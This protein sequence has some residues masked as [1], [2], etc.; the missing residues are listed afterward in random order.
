VH[1]VPMQSQ[2]SSDGTTPSQ[3][4]EHPPPRTIDVDE[5][6][7]VGGRVHAVVGRRGTDST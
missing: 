5:S 2:D 3:A 1:A 7:R 6:R 4:H